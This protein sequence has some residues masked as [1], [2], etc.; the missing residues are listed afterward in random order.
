METISRCGGLRNCINCVIISA[1]G[2]EFT[3]VLSPQS[4]YND[5]LPSFARRYMYG[6][7]LRL[8]EW[9]SER[10]KFSGTIQEPGRFRRT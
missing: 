5:N 2:A 9:T 4:I 3:T 1:R 10:L 6:G 7:A 8:F